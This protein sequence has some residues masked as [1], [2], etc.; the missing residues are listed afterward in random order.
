MGPI[1][2]EK[3]YA[4]VI[5]RKWTRPR[6]ELPNRSLKV[7][8]NTI[9]LKT[10]AA[11]PESARTVTSSLEPGTV[12]AFAT[13]AVETETNRAVSRGWKPAPVDAKGRLDGFKKS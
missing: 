3:D 1:G 2:P 7:E 5:C 4:P 12:P 6:D 11:A 13:L 9:M 10:K 8:K